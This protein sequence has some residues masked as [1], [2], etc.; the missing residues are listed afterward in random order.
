VRGD[1]NISNSTKL[2]FSWNHQLEHDQNPISIWWNMNGSLPY[3]RL[4]MPT[5]IPMST[6]RTWCMCSAPR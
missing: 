1:Y 4:K 3:R 6:V 5:R 2:F